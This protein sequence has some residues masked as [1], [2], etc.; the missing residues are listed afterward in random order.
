VRHHRLDP[1]QVVGDL[2]HSDNLEPGQDLRKHPVVAVA[3]VVHAEVGDVPRREED[4]TA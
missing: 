3:T 2:R 1:G 4:V